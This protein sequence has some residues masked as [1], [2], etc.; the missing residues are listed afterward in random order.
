M[1]V[2]VHPERTWRPHHHA[3]AEPL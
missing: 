3:P 1:V 2:R